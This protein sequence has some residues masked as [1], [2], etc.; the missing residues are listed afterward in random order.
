MFYF[1]MVNFVL[2]SEDV[3]MNNLFFEYVNF[4]VENIYKIC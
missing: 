2:L 3:N 1:L 4:F